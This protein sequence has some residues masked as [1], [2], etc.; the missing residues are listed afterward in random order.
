[1]KEKSAGGRD[2][3]CLEFGIKDCWN[4]D[5]MNG[6]V[7]SIIRHERVTADSHW[8]QEFVSRAVYI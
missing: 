7:Q 8:M 5:G 6:H 1:M 4:L 2:M 3:H